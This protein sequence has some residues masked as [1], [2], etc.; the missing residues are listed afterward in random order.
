MV[1]RF[2]TTARTGTTLPALL[3]KEVMPVYYM[4]TGSTSRDAFDVIYRVTKSI[5]RRYDS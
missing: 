5:R 2:H 3:R 4:T 1:K